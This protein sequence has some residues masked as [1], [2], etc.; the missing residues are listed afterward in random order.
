VCFENVD[1]RAVT[2]G[3]IVLG[4]STRSPRKP[5]RRGAAARQSI[6]IE[7]YPVPGAGRW[8]NRVIPYVVRSGFDS[9]GLAQIHTG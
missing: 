1:G 4:D 5:R 8:A 9:S 2:E 3:D 7:A 6:H